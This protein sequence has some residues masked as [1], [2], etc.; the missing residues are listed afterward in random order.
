M[1]TIETFIDQH[2]WNLGLR[3]PIWWRIFYIRCTFT[4]TKMTEIVQEKRDQSR[5]SK[6]N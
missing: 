1:K 5:G 4:V 6:P 2:G 3:V